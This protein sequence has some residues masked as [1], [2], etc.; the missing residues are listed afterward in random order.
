[1]YTKGQKIFKLASEI[2]SVC[3]TGNMWKLIVRVSEETGKRKKESGFV[4]PT[5]GVVYALCHTE[6]GLLYHTEILD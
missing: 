5:A 4:V 2:T 6:G 1:M 3:E